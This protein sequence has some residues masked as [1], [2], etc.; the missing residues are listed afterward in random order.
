MLPTKFA[1][2]AQAAFP[3]QPFQAEIRIQK[4]K[5]Q[6]VLCT[7]EDRELIQNMQKRQGAVLYLGINYD[8]KKFSTIPFQ[9][10][11]PRLVEG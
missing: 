6:L 11:V 2:E 9:V 1:L 5:I 10:I 3:E 7:V 8:F 4:A